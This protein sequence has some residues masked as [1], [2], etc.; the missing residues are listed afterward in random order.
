MIKRLLTTTAAA[1]LGISIIGADRAEAYQVDCAILL[2]L[3]GGWPSSGPCAHARAVFIRRI[4]PFPIE[5]PLQIWRCPMGIAASNASPSQRLMDLAFK[6]APPPMTTYHPDDNHYDTIGPSGF[7]NPQSVSITLNEDHTNK[8]KLTLA[9]MR[10]EDGSFDPLAFLQLALTPGADVDVSGPEFAFIRSI[11]V[12]DIDVRQYYR[13]S[14]DG[15]ECDRG[16][17]L[18]MGVYDSQGRFSWRRVGAGS[19]PV[20]AGLSSYGRDCPGVRNRSVF[21]EWRDHEGNYDYEA[22]HY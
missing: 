15:G 10:R 2:C 17:R 16:G 4:T 5:P 13:S 21:I 19:A 18:R 9:D 6:D 22:V 20:Q 14:S 12:F 11:R 7:N 1:V 3:A 8:A